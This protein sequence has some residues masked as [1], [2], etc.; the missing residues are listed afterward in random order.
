[1]DE[2]L[3][4]NE[5]D[6]AAVARLRN[7]I[8]QTNTDT[9]PSTTTNSSTHTPVPSVSIDEGAHKYVL[10]SAYPPSSTT[11]HY[12]VTSKRGASYHRNAAEPLV[13][14]LTEGGYGNIEVTGGGRI[15]LDEEERKISVFGFSYGF[16]LADHERSREVIMGDGRYGDYEVVVSDEGY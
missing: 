10:V 2:I 13:D 12:F 6:Q 5:E 15:F 3:T 9:S 11:K 7:R 8:A 4:T 1:M 16:G 14:R